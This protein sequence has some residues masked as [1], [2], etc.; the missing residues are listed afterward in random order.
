MN[1]T[2]NQELLTPDI[3]ARLAQLGYQ[4]TDNPIMVAKFINPNGKGAWYISD[5]TPNLQTVTMYYMAEVPEEDEWIDMFIS[6]FEAMRC[7]P[8]GLPVERD[9]TFIETRFGDLERN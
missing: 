8:L 6:E 9:L 7:Q 2:I 5:Y 4:K 1:T 3:M